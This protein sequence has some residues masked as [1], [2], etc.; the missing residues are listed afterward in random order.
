MSEHIP[1]DELL[2]S[3]EFTK[4]EKLF[5]VITY[6]SSYQQDKCCEIYD[7]EYDY[8]GQGWWHWS[9]SGPED[10]LSLDRG[11]GLTIIGYPN[12]STL[13]DLISR[14][15]LLDGEVVWCEKCKCV[16][17]END[18]YF[19]DVIFNGKRYEDVRIL[20]DHIFWNDELGWW[21]GPGSDEATSEEQSQ[22][23]TIYDN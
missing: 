5:T 9:G 2:H 15:D 19:G 16:Y 12:I 10:E 21:D 22:E 4:D 14:Y 3:I 11:E 6:S 20:C 23:M 7:V 17:P 8:K 1:E 18:T 13:E